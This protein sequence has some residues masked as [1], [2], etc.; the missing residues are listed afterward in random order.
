MR[1]CGQQNH[2]VWTGKLCATFLIP[3][4]TLFKRDSQYLNDEFLIA[5]PG[6]SPVTDGVFF[7]FYQTIVEGQQ[8]QIFNRR[9]LFLLLM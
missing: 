3:A 1:Q 8:K 5:F 4:V 9:Y 2:K 6:V 7:T